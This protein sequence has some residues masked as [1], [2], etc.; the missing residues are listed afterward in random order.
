MIDSVQAQY[1][2]ARIASYSGD[3]TGYSQASSPGVFSNL[4]LNNWAMN[5]RYYDTLQQIISLADP[6]GG[7]YIFPA[8]ND[9]ELLSGLPELTAYIC[10]DG[11]YW[12]RYFTTG[13]TLYNVYVSFPAYIPVYLRSSYSV[14]GVIPTRGDSL[15]RCFTLNVV[16]SSTTDTL[17]VTGRTE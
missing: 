7:G 1:L 3:L 6:S 8:G 5:N 17:Q 11:S 9:N 4:Y 13:D 2:T 10:A 12:Y 16:R 15:N 14:V